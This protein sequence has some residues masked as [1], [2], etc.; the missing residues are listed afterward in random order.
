LAE[1]II[2][3]EVAAQQVIK[4]LLV[5]QG[6]PGFAVDLLFQIADAHH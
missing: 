6:I 1:W 2:N 3:N 4:G 5:A